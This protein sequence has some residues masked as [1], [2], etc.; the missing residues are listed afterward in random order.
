MMPECNHF[1][2]ALDMLIMSRNAEEESG[3]AG[4]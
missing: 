1:V 4:F 3:G 2:D